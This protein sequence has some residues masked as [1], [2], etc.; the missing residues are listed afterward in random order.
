MRIRSRVCLVFWIVSGLTLTLLGGAS[1]AEESVDETDRWVT[2]VGAFSGAIVQGVDASLMS[3]QFFNPGLKTCGPSQPDPAISPPP[4]PPPSCADSVRPPAS[5]NDV[6]VA[7]FVGGT[8]ELMAPSWTPLPGRPRLF[9]HGD[10]SAVFAFDRDIAKEGSPGKMVNP[11]QAEFPEVAVLGQGSKAS[12]EV[13]P[14]VASAGA[15]IAFSLDVWQRR[16]RIKPS[17]EWFREEVRFSGSVDRAVLTNPGVKSPTLSTWQFITMRGGR[18]RTFTGTGPGLELEVDT[19]RAGPFMATL[20]AS[21][22]AYRILGN[23]KVKFKSSFQT[24]APELGGQ[25]VNADWSFEK[26]AWT[27][28]GGLGLRFRWVPE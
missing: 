10:L 26:E 8:L 6:M 23:R 1:A 28:R 27:F 14:L 21:A 2:A 4:P 18:S 16:L 20:F 19:L 5:G 3:S 7:P 22:Q 11:E 13:Q 9:V 24:T 17:V 25:V 15:G 12:A